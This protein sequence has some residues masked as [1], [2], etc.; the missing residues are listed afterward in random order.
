MIHC[1]LCGRQ[2]VSYQVSDRMCVGGEPP[3]RLVSGFCCHECNEFDENGLTPEEADSCR[4]RGLIEDGLYIL[5]IE[6]PEC[7]HGPLTFEIEA[8]ATDDGDTLMTW[9]D[10]SSALYSEFKDTLSNYSLRKQI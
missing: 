6:R 9:T 5:T 2:I 4:R 10:G 1:E 7:T 8:E 3:I